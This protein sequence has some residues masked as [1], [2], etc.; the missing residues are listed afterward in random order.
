MVVVVVVVMNHAIEKRNWDWELVLC[1][2]FII[3]S[4]K[5]SDATK[6]TN[7]VFYAPMKMVILLLR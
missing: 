4:N 2:L 6:E 5:E 3:P 7:G 1:V